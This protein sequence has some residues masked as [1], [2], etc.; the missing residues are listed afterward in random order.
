VGLSL[1]VE[2]I[3]KEI[4]KD[5]PFYQN[6]G[7]GVTF[8]G[9]EPLVQ[10]QFLRAVSQ[11]CREKNI[12][13]AI[14]TTGCAPWEILDKVLDYVDLALSDIKQLDP[15]IHARTVGVGNKLI[16]ENFPRTARKVKTWLRVPVIPGFNDTLDFI[17]R[18]GEF[19]RG[20]GV[21]R[22]S[23]LPYHS[24]GESKYARLGKEYTLKGV[25]PLTEEDLQGL[26][27]SLESYGLS[28]TVG[29]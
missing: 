11:R 8:S 7:G 18:L 29:W 26:K 16:L 14:E 22:V 1:T 25:K 24:W 28:T 9:G 12:H 2:E 3:L 10:W 27:N 15:D 4:E 6:S 17:R 21:E 13:V 5:V 19:C 23:L 20:T